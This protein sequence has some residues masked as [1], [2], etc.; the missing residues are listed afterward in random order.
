MSQG[1]NRVGKPRN[2]SCAAWIASARSSADR[3]AHSLKL[4]CMVGNLGHVKGDVFGIPV[5]LVTGYAVRVTPANE[6]TVRLLTHLVAA[7]IAKAYDF[8]ASAT[9]A[10]ALVFWVICS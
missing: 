9:H 2:Q 3:S 5:K 6:S 7:D 4:I 8:R 1:N 10:A